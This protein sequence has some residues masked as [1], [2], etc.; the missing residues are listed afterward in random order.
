VPTE[1][2][3]LAE[4]ATSLLTGGAGTLIDMFLFETGFL[5]I[6]KNSIKYYNILKFNP[7]NKP[8]KD[9]Q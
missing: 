2:N 4:H 5:S 8:M 9:F 3:L 6:K 1:A 7:E